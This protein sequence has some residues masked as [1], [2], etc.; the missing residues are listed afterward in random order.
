M[1]SHLTYLKREE[2]AA[3]CIPLRL[4]ERLNDITRTSADG[5]LHL[6]VLLADEEAEF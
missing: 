1:P 6:V 4:D 2:T 5:D 3:S